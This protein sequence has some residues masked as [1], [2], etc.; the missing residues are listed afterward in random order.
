MS[1]GK[2]KGGEGEEGVGTGISILNEKRLFSKN[3][4]IIIVDNNI[5]NNNN[6]NN[7]KAI[8]II[9]KE[10]QM[11]D[12]IVKNLVRRYS[13]QRPNTKQGLG[14]RSGPGISSCLGFQIGPGPFEGPVEKSS[15]IQHNT[16]E[17][18]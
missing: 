6:N 14:H 2:R 11:C 8:I 1:G 12:D 5:N 13:N 9:I 15:T 3:K 16:G 17:L 7:K 18:V 4:I 10:K